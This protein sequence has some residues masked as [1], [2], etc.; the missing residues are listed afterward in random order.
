MKTSC[1]S[2]NIKK[3]FLNFYCII[4]FHSILFTLFLFLFFIILWIEKHFGS[5][6]SI[7]QILNNIFSPTV[8]ADPELI[9]SLSKRIINVSLSG[10]LYFLFFSGI[11]Q[12]WF[13]FI[14]KRLF[15]P[16]SKKETK[17][18]DPSCQEISSEKLINRPEEIQIQKS[19]I[20]RKAKLWSLIIPV[21]LFF[22]TC[23]LAEKKFRIID[24]FWYGAQSTPMFDCYRVPDR[25]EIIAPAQKRNFVWIIS[26]SLEETYSQKDL[27]GEDLI[28]ELTSLKDQGL[29][30]PNW[31]QA[32]GTEWTIAS[33]ISSLYGIPRRHVWNGHAFSQ[34][35]NVKILE[36]TRSVF[37]VLNDNGYKIVFVQG[38][39]L[40]FAGRNYLFANFPWMKGLS[41][42]DLSRTPD[43]MEFIK[44]NQ[45][46][47]WGVHDRL[48]LKSACQEFDRLA[49]QESP[50][51]LVV[52]LL[53][54][55]GVHGFRDSQT[56]QQ[57]GDFRDI[58]RE[59]SRMISQ[60]VNKVR[61]SSQ[62][63]NI[64]V[65]IMGDHLAMRNEVQ[66]LLDKASDRK[67]FNLWIN[68]DPNLK[69]MT[70]APCATFDFAPAILEFLG[71]RWK[72]H[73]FGIGISCFSNDQRLL[74][75]YS[76]EK[77]QN[78]IN[79]ESKIY[80]QLILGNTSSSHK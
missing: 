43:Y 73:Q 80:D 58:I 8:G 28:T 52:Q 71:F 44:H 21:I 5:R 10:I 54:T 64:A 34:N 68:G 48:V 59:Q 31:V 57:Y 39:D 49:A 42:K 38:D 29:I 75:K 27:F 55:H 40:A 41:Y 26:E 60:F 74:Q 1:N 77:Y 78:E 13:D 47:S 66:N 16:R 36:N 67:I 46:Y 22:L 6:L 7:H 24:Y 19:D 25:S 70:D 79:K 3:T 51:V 45:G 23:F 2:T 17:Q 4:L 76:Y 32:D 50:F 62:K 20:I 53:D 37:H 63:E 15:S 12:F 33:L 11:L 18:T 72:D 35:V 14:R 30:V 65:L 56:Q 9:R 69:T 61:A